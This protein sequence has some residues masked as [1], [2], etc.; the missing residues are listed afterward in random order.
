MNRHCRTII[1]AQVDLASNQ[2]GHA[3]SKA[4]MPGRV[5]FEE[6]QFPVFRQLTEGQAGDSTNWIKLIVFVQTGAVP[7]QIFGNENNPLGRK[8]NFLEVMAIVQEP[9]GQGL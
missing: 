5:K 2:R 1:M 3:V 8:A 6:L 7:Y 4:G 9:R